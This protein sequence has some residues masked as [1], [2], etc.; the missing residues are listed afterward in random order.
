ML[1]GI[2]NTHHSS[3]SVFFLQSHGSPF[4]VI[5]KHISGLGLRRLDF[6]RCA[7]RLMICRNGTV[8]SLVACDWPTRTASDRRVRESCSPFASTI[9]PKIF[10][11][12]EGIYNSITIY[13]MEG[14]G[15]SEPA[16]AWKGR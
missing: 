9:S 1:P 7:L 4:N 3:H 6:D 15:M 5:P 10:L 11:P 2:E 16:V 13:R 8:I 14:A 12:G